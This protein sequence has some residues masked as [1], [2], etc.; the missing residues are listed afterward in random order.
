MTQYQ[1]L[2]KLRDMYQKEDE[3]L[4]KTRKLINVLK[5][6]T[7]SDAEELSWIEESETQTRIRR[8][9]IEL[10]AQHLFPELN[11]N[12]WGEIY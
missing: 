10:V 6:D 3:A 2:I 4:D 8:D 9:C 7:E 5:D 11:I 12:F 1:M